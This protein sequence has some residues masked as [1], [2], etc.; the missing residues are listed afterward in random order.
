[1]AQIRRRNLSG[2]HWH[3]PGPGQKADAQNDEQSRE[4]QLD[5]PVPAEDALGGKQQ[6]QAENKT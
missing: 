3:L 5:H 4:E 6:H 1:M 2:G